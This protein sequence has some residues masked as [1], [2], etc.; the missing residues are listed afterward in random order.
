MW[1]KL[2]IWRDQYFNEELDHW[3]WLMGQG[4]KFT[5]K[6]MKRINELAKAEKLMSQ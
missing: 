4:T 1:W 3:I 5:K 6:Q 2:K